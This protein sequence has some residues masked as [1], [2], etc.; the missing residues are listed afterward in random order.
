MGDALKGELELHCRGITVHPNLV[1]DSV[2]D[3]DRVTTVSVNRI[4]C[5]R[6]VCWSGCCCT[7]CVAG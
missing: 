1:F 6:P 4:G 7:K 2:F 3:V 5:F